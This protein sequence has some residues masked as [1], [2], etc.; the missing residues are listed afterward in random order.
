MAEGKSEKSGWLTKKCREIVMVRK[1]V[2]KMVVTKIIFV[3]IPP[4]THTDRMKRTFQTKGSC[5]V[6]MGS[7]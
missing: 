6:T 5:Y 3:T 2:T 4:P 1:S 7:L